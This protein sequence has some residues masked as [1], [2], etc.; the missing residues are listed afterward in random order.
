[1]KKGFTLIELLVVVLIIGILSAIALPQYQTAVEKARATE[2]VS[3]AASIRYAGERYRMQMGSFP[4]DDM[5]SLDIEVP[6]YNSSTKK[7]TTKNFEI[8]TANSGT[9]Y[10]VSAKR[11]S[12]SQYIISIAVAPDG[13]AKRYCAAAAATVSS[14]GV[15]TAPSAA[16]NEAMLKLCKAITSGNDVNGNW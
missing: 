16:T 8:T 11:S 7:A 15:I 12:G 4:G 10:V 5:G 3:L 13:N 9:G 6:G 14:A 1:M 2:A